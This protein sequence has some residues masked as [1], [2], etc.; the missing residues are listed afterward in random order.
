MDLM[1]LGPFP[2]SCRGHTHILAVT[3]HYTKWVEAVP[4]QKREPFSVAKG[5]AS[6]FYRWVFWCQTW[7]LLRGQIS[8]NGQ[9]KSVESAGPKSYKG[10]NP[11]PVT[12]ACTVSYTDWEA[13]WGQRIF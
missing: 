8:T 1:F 4:L 7:V 13:A 9:R 6:V 12:E 5:L 10:P 2:E 3:D 11:N